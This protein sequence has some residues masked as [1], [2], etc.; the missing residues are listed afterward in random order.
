MLVHMSREKRIAY[1]P[2]YIGYLLKAAALNGAVFAEADDWGSAAVWVPPGKKIDN[3]WTIPQSGMLNV[4]W[5]CGLRGCW[6]MLGEFQSQANAVKKKGLKGQKRFW[7][8]WFI[9]TSRDR[10]GKGGCTGVV[11]GKYELIK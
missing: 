7:Y 4:L 5:N 1:L 8:L 3:T 2:K 11:I 6:R 9:G 10:Q